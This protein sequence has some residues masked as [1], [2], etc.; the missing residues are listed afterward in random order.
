[1]IEPKVFD[2]GIEILKKIF[3]EDAIFTDRKY[4]VWYEE[5]SS[6]MSSEEFETAINKAIFNF[7]QCPTGEQILMLAKGYSPKFLQQRQLNKESS[8]RL[9]LDTEFAEKVKAQERLETD[10]QDFIDDPEVNSFDDF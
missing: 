4:R 7:S 10:P 1:M 8:Y 9:D 6:Q 2:R 5:L 3:P